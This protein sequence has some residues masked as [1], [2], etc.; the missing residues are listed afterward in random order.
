MRRV[1]G[2]NTSFLLSSSYPSFSGALSSD[3]ML[4]CN[5][6]A[7]GPR[8]EVE[9]LVGTR[10]LPGLESWESAHDQTAGPSVRKPPGKGQK[11]G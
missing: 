5:L 3:A 4:L 6:E 7:K 10:N 11:L 8:G 2:A 1:V 9:T